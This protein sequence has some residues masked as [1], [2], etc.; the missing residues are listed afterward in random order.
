MFDS[1]LALPPGRLYVAATLLP[2]AAFAALLA[3]G[4]LRALCRPHRDRPV[5]GAGLPRARRRHAA[6]R[7]GVPRAGEHGPVGVP[8]H[9]RARAVPSGRRPCPSAARRPLVR[10]QG[11]GPHRRGRHRPAGRVRAAAPG[12]PRPGRPPNGSG[13]RTR[14][15]HRPPDCPALRHGHRRRHRHRR[16]LARLHGRRDRDGRGGP[17]GRQA[18]AGAGAG[19][20][21]RRARHHAAGVRRRAAR[22]RRPVALPPPRPVRPVLPVPGPV[23]L[24]HAQPADRGQPVPG[25]R[26]LGAGRRL[27]VL[28]DRLLL[29][30]A[31]GRRGRR[32]RRSS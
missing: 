10:T 7:G 32:T 30:A 6:A 15:P 18:A 13:T 31:V 20:S 23:L 1:L 24:L 3:A 17:R 21:G 9:L 14:L 16:L 11:L 27:L 8:G 5:F 4:T 19:A 2:L 12:E 22:P 28:P 25:V 26:E 29:R